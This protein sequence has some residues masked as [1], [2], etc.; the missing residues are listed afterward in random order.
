MQT[1][2]FL[3]FD[4]GNV[5]LTFDNERMTR[6]LAEVADVETS[7]VQQLLYANDDETDLQWRFE[8]GQYT[9]DEYYTHFCEQLNVMPDRAAFDTAVADMFGAIEPSM[10]LADHLAMADW[11]LGLLS[12]T[13]A[14]HWKWVLDGRFPVLN[15]AFQQQVTSFDAKSMKPDPGI[16]QQA[17]RQAGVPAER[18]FFV[19][20]R[21]EN[22]E[23]ARAAG[24]DAVQFT[25]TKR[26][27]LALVKRKV[28]E[29]N[30]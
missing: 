28:L 5:L 2:E 24:M 29:A 12:N 26:L 15:R 7:L 13:N 22:V 6:Q 30:D 11:P 21:L 20:D 16:Y 18:I 19:D 1:P 14:L 4:L 25:T 27:V 17:I 9:P 10:E 3:Y 8:A 23:G